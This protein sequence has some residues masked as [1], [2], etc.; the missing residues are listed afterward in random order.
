VLIN[1]LVPLAELADYQLR[2]KAITGGQG[3]YTLSFSHYDPLP[4]RRQQELVQA[5]KP[6]SE[7]D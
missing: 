2:L 5:W 7:E 3:S 1:A 4:P 6:R